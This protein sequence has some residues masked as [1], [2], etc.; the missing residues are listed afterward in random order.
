MSLS[1]SF[2]FLKFKTMIVF[3]QKILENKDTSTVLYLLFLTR[4][5][6]ANYLTSLIL[7]FQ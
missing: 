4:F 1:L 6:V 5:Y 7:K 3:I 2:I